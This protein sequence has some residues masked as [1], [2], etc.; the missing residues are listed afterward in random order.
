MSDQTLFIVMVFIVGFLMS[1]A[2]VRP[3][4][5]TGREARRRLRERI[6]DLSDD[7]TGAEQVSL[8]RDRYLRDLSPFA[9]ALMK[10]PGMDGLQA[11]IAQAGAE[12]PP[13]RVL[14]LCVAMGVAAGMAAGTAFGWGLGALLIGLIGTAL[15]ILQLKTKRAKRIAKFEEQLPDAL[16][17]AA[18]SLRAGLPFGEALKLVSQEMPEPVGKEFGI[19]FTEVNYGGDLRGALLGMLERVPSV[20]VMAMVTSV[21][22]Q[23]ET[24]GNLAEVMDKLASVVRERFRFQRTVRT[25]SA[26]G[27]LS[28]W[29]LIS[30]PFLMAGAISAINPEYLPMLTKDPGGRS[31]VM[32]AFGFLVVGILWLRWI[33]R[34]DV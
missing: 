1:Q 29:I 16:T 3:L 33:V 18:R 20:A 30:L 10:L 5:G 28:A 2:F 27:R 31:I 22:I 23:R 12:K 11:L 24:G 6:R 15:P 13:H 25:L 34:I 17:V 26:E 8:L 19:V 4:M 7:A 9:R 21:L 32:A 14:I